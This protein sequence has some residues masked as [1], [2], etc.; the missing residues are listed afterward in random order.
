MNLRGWTR[1]VG[2][3]IRRVI[4][5]WRRRSLPSFARL[6]AHNL[7]LLLAGKYSVANVAFDQEFDRTY[8]VET[9]G[10]EEPEYLTADS[11]LKR[12]ANRYEPVKPGDL[13]FL[14]AVVPSDQVGVSDFVDIGSGKGRALFVAAEFP[15]RECLGVEFAKELHDVATRNIAAFRYAGSRCS[16][17]RSIHADATTFGFPPN[18]IVCFVNNPFDDELIAVL[19][20]N[21]ED[22]IRA[23][24]R[25][26]ALIYLHANHT[27]PFDA[28]PEWRRV[29]S[30][31]LGVAPYVVW[32]HSP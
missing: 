23:A 1:S 7:G 22:S 31:V 18:P 27:R 8:Q 30:G 3:W 4:R 6:V 12:H 13:R 29:S 21:I 32:R 10:T 17:I 28:I 14:L 11:A 15:F 9:A 2:H 16:S 25:P 26:F 5:A 19:A 20:K 24:P